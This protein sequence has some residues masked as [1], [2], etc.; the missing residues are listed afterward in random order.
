MAEQDYRDWLNSIEFAKKNG[1]VLPTKLT[2][3][4]SEDYDD[5]REE[6]E[7]TE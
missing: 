7:P 1:Q 5:D 4:Q 6:E 2:A 3:D